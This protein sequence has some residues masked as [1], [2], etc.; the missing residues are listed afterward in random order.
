[1]T[2]APL[3]LLMSRIV[4]RVVPPSTVKDPV[5]PSVDETPPV[6]SMEMANGRVGSAGS[7]WAG[8]PDSTATKLRS[9]AMKLVSMAERVVDAAD[10]WLEPFTIKSP[11][12]A[13][14]LTAAMPRA[15]V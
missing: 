12:V 13:V 5:I 1:M 4:P 6:F 15:F 2:V 3:G 10:S 8:T 9:S 11:V 14:L 7:G